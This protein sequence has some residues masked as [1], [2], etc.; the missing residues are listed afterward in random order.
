VT[1]QGRRN[2]SQLNYEAIL[3][4][5]DY[6]S[7]YGS[8]W[9]SLFSKLKSTFKPKTLDCVETTSYNSTEQLFAILENRI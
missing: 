9:L 8:L 7:R 6:C 3:R 4:T 2:V 5:S 1:R